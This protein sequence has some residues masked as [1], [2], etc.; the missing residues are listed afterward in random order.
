MCNNI[1]SII[2]KMV[3]FQIKYSHGVYN[4]VVPTYNY[5]YMCIYAC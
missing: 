5:I 3:I 2:G 4:L 1:T